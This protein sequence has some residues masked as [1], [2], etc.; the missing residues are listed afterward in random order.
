M[1]EREYTKYTSRVAAKDRERI[2]VISDHGSYAIAREC[3][4][5]GATRASK[6]K[7]IKEHKLCVSSNGRVFCDH[8]PNFYMDAITGSL[9]KDGKCLGSSNLFLTGITE[10][11]K[12]AVSILMS[13]KAENVSMI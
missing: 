4:N 7:W 2:L 3:F 8:Q 13:L 10:D 11:H 6:A 9:Y 12:R 5:A 1:K